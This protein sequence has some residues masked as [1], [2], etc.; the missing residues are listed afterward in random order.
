MRRKIGLFFAVVAFILFI[1]LCL[2]M[3]G[4]FNITGY[5]LSGVTLL[6]FIGQCTI[7]SFLISAWGYWEI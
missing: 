3:L 5:S 2:G 1:F 7:L 4:V 6:H